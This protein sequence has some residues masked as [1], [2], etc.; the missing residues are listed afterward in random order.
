MIIDIYILS[1]VLLTF[2]NGFIH[3]YFAVKIRQKYPNESNFINSVVISIL[4]IVAGVLYPF[5]FPIDN[6]FSRFYHM[7]GAQ[8]ICI[9]SY[10]VVLFLFVVQYIFRVWRHPGIKEERTIENFLK[11]FNERNEKK[12]LDLKDKSHSIST[13]INRKLFHLIPPG[14][15]IILWEFATHFWGNVF[16]QDVIWGITDVEYG[17]WLIMTIGFTAIMVFGVLD[18]IRL[19]FI[20]EKHSA[21]HL[22]PKNL[23]GIF[24]KTLKRDEIYELSATAALTLSFVPIF[25][26]PISIFAAAALIASIGDGAASLIGI[27][28]GKRHFPK[29]SKKTIIGYEAG[30]LG[31]FVTAIVVYC[32]FEPTMP[33]LKI[34][35]LSLGGALVFLIVDLLNLKIN[36][37]ILNPIF[38]GLFMALLYYAI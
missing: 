5:F 30:F 23:T 9:Y 37:N 1:V 4:W 6:Q 26:F 27:R 12:K 21:Y 31:S 36:D 33:F 24:L 34:T 7:L 8:I 10:A 32:I 35:I 25:F 15:I 16:N 19:S 20:F 17:V 14:V 38:C 3:F 28:F 11:K 2:A 18:Y 13:D 22:M 29:N